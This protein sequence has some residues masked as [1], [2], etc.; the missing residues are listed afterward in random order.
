MNS[1]TWRYA[2]L[3]SL[4]TFLEF[5]D[6]GLELCGSSS[7]Y[8]PSSIWEVRWFYMLEWFVLLRSP[9]YSGIGLWSMFA[10]IFL[11]TIQ[12]FAILV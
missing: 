11:R 7:V 1:D 10:F 9:A 3:K 6:S 4:G 2:L 12:L 8:E 5:G